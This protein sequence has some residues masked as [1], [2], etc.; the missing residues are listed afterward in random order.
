MSMNKLLYGMIS[1]MIVVPIAGCASLDGEPM[2]GEATSAL[3][4]CNLFKGSFLTGT[5]N[6]VDALFFRASDGDA[7]FNPNNSCVI[8]G[9]TLIMQ[10]DGNFVLYLNGAAKWASNTVGRGHHAI[11]QTDGNLAVYNSNNVAVC[12]AGVP[13][14]STNQMWLTNRG[15]LTITDDHVAST[16]FWSTPGSTCH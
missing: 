13:L 10:T 1:S 3:T 2:L 16:I 5:Q 6:G 11:F 14:R 8:D 7:W 15:R 4:N 9:T 12:G